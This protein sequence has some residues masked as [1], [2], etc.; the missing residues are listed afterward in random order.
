MPVVHDFRCP[1]CAKVF[2]SMVPWEQEEEACECGAQARRV[3]ISRREYRAQ[4]FD[5]VLV[6][7]DRRGHFRFPGRN[8]GP[9]PAGYEPVLLH[10]TAEVRNFERQMNQTERDRY[11][12]HQERQ[13]ATYREFISSRRSELR[14]RLHHMSPYG[15]AIAEAAIRQNDNTPSC[16]TRFDAQFHLE[17]F[18]FDASNRDAQ[19]DRDL[20][21]RK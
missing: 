21:R 9:V 20:S 10:T 7:R 14:Q 16:D 4:S 13:E 11:M 3:F 18:S 17:A 2:E 8:S 19:N 15:R 1:K 5:P 12:V 6:Y